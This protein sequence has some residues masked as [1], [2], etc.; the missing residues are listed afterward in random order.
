M[1]VYAQICHQIV[2]ISGRGYMSV[3]KFIPEQVYVCVSVGFGGEVLG[4][5]KVP[6]STYKSLPANRHVHIGD[7]VSRCVTGCGL[8]LCM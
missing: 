8:S 7:L 4:Y 3:Y 6:L 5:V 1:G 2:E